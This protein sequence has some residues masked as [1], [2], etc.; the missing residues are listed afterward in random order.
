MG[1]FYEEAK[2]LAG[3]YNGCQG[4]TTEPF[5]PV[6]NM[7]HVHFHVPKKKLEPILIAIYKETGIGLSSYLR[8]TS[9]EACYYE[10]SLGDRYAAVPK[11]ELHKAF[12]LLDEGLRK[13]GH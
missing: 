9:E 10:V 7:F 3:L 1:Q 11:E 5:E 12:Q 6:S 8:E 13:I 4:I 2:E